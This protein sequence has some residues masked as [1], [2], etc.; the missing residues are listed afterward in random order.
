MG[1]LTVAPFSQHAWVGFSEHVPAAEP[2]VV[3][4][5]LQVAHS[6]MFL[7]AGDVAYRWIHRGVDRRY[8]MTAGTVRFDPATRDRHT[9]I[10]QHNPAHAFFTLL[11]PPV[12][13]GPI[14][15]SDEVDPLTSL[16]SLLVPDD[17]EL[18]W[19][20]A[21]LSSRP[22]ADGDH[23]EAAR[24]LL[25]RLHR[26]GGGRGP[27]WRR[28]SSAFDR[29]TL[30]LLVDAIDAH[31]Q[32]PPT[33]PGMAMLTALSPSHF[34]RKFRLSTGLSLRRFINRRRISASIPLLQARSLPLAAIALDLG[35]SSQ[36]H[37]T[38]LFSDLT[39][40]TPAKYRKQFRRT[41]GWQP[42]A[43]QRSPCAH[44]PRLPR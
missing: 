26:L 2:L 36:S 37:F 11:I 20:M 42:Q 5:R 23:E 18:R 15:E 44:R 3:V 22:A 25:L 28:D 8:R 10:G 30:L 24:R 7:Q 34:A 39:G 9:F 29:S 43:G 38:R 35:F 6:V 40:M 33:L 14:L 17:S 12:D 1:A 41:V 27:E 21:R 31:L 13:I 19:C 4:H 16:S 32:H